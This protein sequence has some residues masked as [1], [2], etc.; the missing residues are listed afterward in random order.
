MG[1]S[2]MWLVSLGFALVLVGWVA[3][4]VAMVNTSLWSLVVFAV[5]AAI[6]VVIKKGF[7]ND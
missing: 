2:Y 7:L 3:I 1:D 6:T 5:I 4:L